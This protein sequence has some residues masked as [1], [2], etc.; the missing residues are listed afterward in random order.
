M[1]HQSIEKSVHALGELN[2]PCSTMI[3][4]AERLQYSE[5]NMVVRIA[6][7]QRSVGFNPKGGAKTLTSEIQTNQVRFSELI[8]YCVSA[9]LITPTQVVH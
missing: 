9:P 6:L 8:R 1:L 3:S 7:A 4:A 5:V 2:R